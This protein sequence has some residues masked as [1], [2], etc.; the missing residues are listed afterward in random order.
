MNNAIL[1]T[2]DFSEPSHDVVKYAVNLAKQFDCRITI[3]YAYRLMYSK[4]E[5]AVELRKKIEEKAKQPKSTLTGIAL[6][7]YPKATIPLVKQ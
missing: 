2:I 1:C 6:Y 5:E 7:Y 3:L 4:G